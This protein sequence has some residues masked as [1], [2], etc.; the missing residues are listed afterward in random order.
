MR[1]RLRIGAEVSGSQY[2][3]ARQEQ[4]AAGNASSPRPSS[5]TISSWHPTCGIPAPLIE[6]SEG[7]ETTRLLTR[8]TYPF[9]LAPTARAE[10]PVRVYPRARLPVGM[11]LIAPAWGGSQY[12][13]RR[14]RAYQQV[15]DWHLRQPN[16]E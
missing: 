14:H 3:L 1:T 13:A 2:A 12:S 15:T 9:S 7:V 10:R 5:A 8:F 16:A 4:R 6:E 11:Q